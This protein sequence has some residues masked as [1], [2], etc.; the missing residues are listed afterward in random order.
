MKRGFTLIE[1]LIV[2]VIV[3]ILVTIALP[4]Y[5]AA[6]ERARSMEGLTNL[7]EASEVMNA[8]YVMKGNQCLVND[9]IDSN[10]HLKTGDFIKSKN[11][12]QPTVTWVVESGVCSVDINIQREDGSATPPYSLTAHNENGE[13]KYISCSNAPGTNY[14]EEIGADDNGRLYDASEN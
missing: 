4:K 14:C 9:V 7:K 5:N 12:A 13:L 6:M 3:G 8:R 1:L 10:H 2:M 11:F